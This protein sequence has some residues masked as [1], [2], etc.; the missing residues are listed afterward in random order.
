MT[1]EF[2]FGFMLGIII[3]SVIDMIIDNRRRKEIL[4]LID[5]IIEQNAHIKKHIDNIR[6]GTKHV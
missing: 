3:F 5:E 1:M 6:D 4:R 2:W